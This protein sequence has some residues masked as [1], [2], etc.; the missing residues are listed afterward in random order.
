M[1]CE[2]K[3]D[4]S[5]TY[6]PLAYLRGRGLTAETIQ[7]AQL[8]YVPGRPWEWHTFDKLRVPCGITIPWFAD[9]ALWAVKVRRAAGLPKYTQVPGGNAHGL[10][11]ADDLPGHPVVLVVEGE[12]D[13]LLAQQEA[14]G[15]AAVTTLGSASHTLGERWL[16]ILA[17]CR[18]NL[19]AY[20]RTK[21]GGRG[22][23]AGRP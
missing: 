19:V 9:D 10:Y 5:H 18:L 6:R 22:R 3:P 8:G 23:L 2:G 1:G 13:A 4:D 20:D 12:F 17:A 15:L 14:A 11:N 16:P 7:R 21:R